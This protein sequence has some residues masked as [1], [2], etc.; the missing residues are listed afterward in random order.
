MPSPLRDN[1]W[2]EGRLKLLWGKYYSD[3]PAGLPIE[4]R[5]GRPAQY[6]F[7]SIRQKGDTCQ[8]YMNPLF[9]HPDV[10]DYVID[11]T[12]VHELAHYVHGYGSGLTKLHEHP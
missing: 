6:R 4:V 5:F 9:A 1:E 12:M 10:P 8:I 3:A 7:G 2:L 11:A